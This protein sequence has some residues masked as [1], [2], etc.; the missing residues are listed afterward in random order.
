MRRQAKRNKR[1]YIL[2]EARQWDTDFVLA[3]ACLS[4]LGSM[5][6]LL[7]AMLAYFP[8]VL[9]AILGASRSF[10]GGVCL[11]GC[12]DIPPKWIPLRGLS[13]AWE[14]PK[15]GPRRLQQGSGSNCSRAFLS[16]LAPRHFGALLGPPCKPHASPWGPWDD[17]R[18]FNA[19]ACKYPPPCLEARSG[20]PRALTNFQY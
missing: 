20:G 7:G 19:H 1:T 18:S 11:T 16:N 4:T 8:L 15:R 12:G 3:G 14:G 17:R 2:P 13:R 9:C 10:R 6:E 5:L